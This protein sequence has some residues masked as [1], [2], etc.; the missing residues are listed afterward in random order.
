MK[1]KE[2]LKCR[3]KELAEAKKLQAAKEK[4][5][6]VT[7]QALDRLRGWPDIDQWRL[8]QQEA[9]LKKKSN[10]L[11]QDRVLLDQ[12]EKAF[13]AELARIH[14]QATCWENDR[15]LLGQVAEH[16]EALQ[17]VLAEKT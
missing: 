15:K 9:A 4:D 2:A 17:D 6:Q 11:K 16:L 12:K 13:E 10:E 8:A 5:I 3:A 1:A 14:D 7:Q